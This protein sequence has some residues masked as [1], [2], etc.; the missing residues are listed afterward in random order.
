[1]ERLVKNV[2]PV[3]TT[4]LVWVLVVVAGS[5]LGAATTQADAGTDA[6]QLIDPGSLRGMSTDPPDI[7]NGE[8]QT[9]SIAGDTSRASEGVGGLSEKGAQPVRLRTCQI[10]DSLVQGVAGQWGVAVSRLGDDSAERSLLFGINEGTPVAPASVVKL[11]TAVAALE[12]L[13][14][15]FRF[16]T[17]VVEGNVPGEIWLV[18]GGDVTL[19]RAAGWNYYDSE[20]HLEELAASTVA[21]LATGRSGSD[22]TTA[23]AIERVW[24]D[25]SRYQR[26]APWD[27]SWRPGSAALGYVAPVSALQVDGDRDNP[28]LRL[29]PRS[30]DP[31]SRAATWFGDAL[32]RSG[33]GSPELVFGQKAPEGRLLAEVSSA[34]LTQ[35]LRIMLVDSDNSLAEVISREVAL[36][37]DPRGELGLTP[38]EAVLEAV[39]AVVDRSNGMSADFSTAD[40]SEANVSEADVSEA[41]LLEGAV[42]HDGSGLSPLSALSPRSVLALLHVIERLPELEPVR[43]GLPVAG[44]SGSLRNRYQSVS[45]DLQGLVQAK[46]GSIRGTRSL[47]GYLESSE[48]NGATGERLVFSVVLSGNR[49]SDASRGDIDRLVGALAQCGENLADWNDPI[50]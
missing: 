20:A 49:V 14:P 13:G 46:T 45:R 19:T 11:F 9:A 24:V 22:S 34:P 4:A 27:D 36:S 44:E 18:G 5:A 50:N 28:A 35:L 47:A 10:T 1:V 30:T 37:L 2:F 29:S 31:S 48:D 6:S 41:D 40:V 21:S 43:E 8:D 16:R 26:F 15:D 42:I 32:R 25:D 39:R 3:L 33:G 12:T 23:G 7:E 38:G 17:Q